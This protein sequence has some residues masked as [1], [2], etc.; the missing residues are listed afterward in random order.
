AFGKT[1]MRSPLTPPAPLSHGGAR[2][3]MSDSP[4]PLCGRGVGGEG[5]K[6][7]SLKT[8]TVPA[9]EITFSP[10]ENP[11]GGGSPL[12]SLADTRLG[13]DASPVP[14]EAAEARSSEWI[15]ARKRSSSPAG[16]GSW[17]STSSAG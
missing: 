10:T 8:L 6:G 2:G 4:S 1:E 5:G 16:P 14:Q 13:P 11:S 7:R 17:G 12:N 9:G 3:E 15:C